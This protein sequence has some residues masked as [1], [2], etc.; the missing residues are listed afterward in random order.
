[1]KEL[2]WKQRIARAKKKGEF[3]IVDQTLAGDFK[4]CAVGEKFELHLKKN[5]K[6]VN[7]YNF[8]AWNKP[9][10]KYILGIDF[11]V[12][13]EDN[14]IKEVQQI[15]NKIQKLTVVGRGQ[16]PSNDVF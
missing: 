5:R 15:Y 2:T 4:T 11:N 13:V 14:E 16:K 10:E 7:F 9:D 1:M 12:K 8:F 6:L 3:T